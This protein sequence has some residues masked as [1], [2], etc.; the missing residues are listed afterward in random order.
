M[1]KT[2]EEHS[3]HFALCMFIVIGIVLQVFKA[4]SMT[5]SFFVFR[6]VLHLQRSYMK[7][8]FGYP[9]IFISTARIRIKGIIIHT[10]CDGFHL[11][12]LSAE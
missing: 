11:K 12:S 4:N 10:Y 2:E 1:K 7:I 6:F 8:S 9:K 3:V 5:S